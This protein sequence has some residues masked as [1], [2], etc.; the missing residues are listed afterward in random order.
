MNWYSAV[1]NPCDGHGCSHLCLLS[2]TATNGYSC[3]CP[4]GY[5]LEDDEVTCTG[6]SLAV[7]T[8]N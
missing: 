4:D 8:G 7:T 2:S 3:A 6:E 1:T 5:M